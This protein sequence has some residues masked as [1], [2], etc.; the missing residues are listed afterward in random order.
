MDTLMAFLI[1]AVCVVGFIA[2]WK[3]AEKVWP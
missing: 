1:I 3:I 2:G